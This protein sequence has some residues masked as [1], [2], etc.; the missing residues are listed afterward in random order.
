MRTLLPG[1]LLIAALHAADWPRFR[2]PN[3]AGVDSST[4]LPVEFSPSKNLLWKAAVPF[5]RSSPIVAGG[6]VFLTASE[7]DKRLTLAFDTLTG[8]QL[9]RRELKCDQTN[10][11][12]RTNDPASPTP[13]A[14]DRAIYVFF[15]DFGLISYTFEGEERWRRALGP[16]N[17]FYG[18]ATSPVVAQGLVLLL[19]D[20]QSGSYLIGIDKDTGRDR[21]RTERP[22]ASLGWSVPI[23][24]SPSK[25]AAEIIAFGSA[26]VDS[27]YLATGEQRWWLP[28]GSDGSMGSPLIAGDTAIVT[29]SGHDQ[30]WMPSF[31][32]ALAKYDKD[33]DGRIS[34]EEFKEDKDW[35]EHF[36]WIDSSHDGFIDT[37]EWNAARTFGLGDY[38]VMAIPLA[39]KGQLSSK[40]LRWQFKRNLA[41]IP[42]PLIYD[43]VFYMVRTGGIVTSLQPSSGAVLKQGRT[44][45]APG[46]YYASPVAADGKIFFVSEEGK[47]SVLKASPQWEVLAVNNLEE[48]TY[49]TPAISGGRIYVRTRGTL[50]CFGAAALPPP[51]NAR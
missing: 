19:C 6:R 2:G 35:S 25:D 42:S 31:D 14:A 18:M 7:G 46:E 26:R 4:G 11:V 27:Y 39:G 45:K 32:S 21:W 50:Y 20:Q 5:A 36:G 51:T 15:P 12:F 3:G 33:G 23:V 29:A 41:Y 49:A 16:F 40:V 22:G 37:R 28:I 1:L 9:W 13:A 47:V 44:E 43:G 48:D 17:N 24:Y 30:P 34:R 10:K 38:G 8:R